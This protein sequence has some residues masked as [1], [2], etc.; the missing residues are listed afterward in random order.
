MADITY[1]EENM[2][3]VQSLNSEVLFSIDIV[4]QVVSTGG[5]CSYEKRSGC[6][7]SGRK[8][9]LRS[10]GCE[11]SEAYSPYLASLKTHR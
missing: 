4:E 7:H 1:S 8:T 3:E 9:K 5:V 6:A 11:C 2:L 10:F